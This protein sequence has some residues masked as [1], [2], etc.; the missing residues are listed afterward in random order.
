MALCLL[1]LADLHLGSPMNTHLS[2]EKAEERRDE[3]LNTFRRGVQY[4]KEHGVTGILLSGDV[5]DSERPRK[6]DKMFFYDV[7]ERAPDITFFYLRGNHDGGI[8][9]TRE[10][11]N[12]KLFSDEWQS[13]LLENGTGDRV[14]VTGLELSSQNA[15]SLYAGLELAPDACNIVMLHGQ[16][17]D[18]EGEGRIVLRRLADKCIDY[19]ALGHVHA[20]TEGTLDRRGRYCYCG[21][22]EGRGFDEPGR[23]GFVLLT[24]EKGKIR[25][26][27]VPFASRIVYERTVD[28]SAA[29]SVTRALDMVQDA[30]EDI[31]PEDL[32]RLNLTG[33]ISFERER[34]DSMVKNALEPDFYAVSV[35]DRTRIAIDPGQ[36]EGDLSLRGA[37][38]RWVLS[39]P[40]LSE[41]DREIV[42][43]YG[44]K[45]LSGEKPEI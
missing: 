14:T 20:Y 25:T 5:F 19:L 10:L 30:V 6:K 24:V 33:R 32:L 18:N 8:S 36:F 40:S 43:A 38:A 13:Y 35:K 37:F 34:L 29:D 16:I 45:A 1:H 42:L 7:I 44:L 31:P 17:G 15:L 41:E 4:A 39:D 3:L 21:C 9:Y 26:E 27:F 12:L 23:H 22:P 2:N 11:P 28:L